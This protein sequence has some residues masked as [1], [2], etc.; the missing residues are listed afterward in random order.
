M[1]HAPNTDAPLIRAASAGDVIAVEQLLQHGADPDLHDA[2]GRSALHHAVA[3]GDAQTAACL[4]AYGAS[5]ARRDASGGAALD[6]DRVSLDV[7]HAIRQRLHRFR[8]SDE[9][10]SASLPCAQRWARELDQRGIAKLAGCVAPGEL[11]LMRRE[12]AR[13]VR[14]LAGKIARSEGVKRHY[15]E[16]EHWWPEERALITNNA[17]KHSAQL[18]RFSSRPELLEAARLYLGRP[19]FV[20]RALAMRYL[21]ASASQ[22]DMFAWHHDLE[23][24]RLKVMI[25]LSDVGP[26]DQHMSY[27]C[28]SQTLFHPYRMFLDNACDLAYC[29]QHLGTLEIYDAVGQAGDVFLFDTNGAHRAIRRE[30]GRVRDAFLVEFNASTANLWG[31]DIAASL[32]A[33]LRLEHDPFARFVAAEKKWNLP[34]AQTS[35]SWASSLPHPH[36]WL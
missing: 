15:F 16:E 17:F 9:R 23:D 34:S 10:P 12:F 13:F 36:T 33:E 31:G 8:R 32:L 5:Y 27:V 6:P 35:P 25:L 1:R 3:A 20:Q 18:V 22:R 28:G 14:A 11:D 29:R 4:L 30:T 7:L 26:D 2:H 24:K 19:P 21:A